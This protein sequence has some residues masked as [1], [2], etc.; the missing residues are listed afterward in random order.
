VNSL[1]KE[2]SENGVLARAARAYPQRGHSRPTHASKPSMIM[3]G[4]ITP[5][6]PL[7]PLKAY[8]QIGKKPIEL[9]I[10]QHCSVQ[11]VIECIIQVI[12]C[13][14]CTLVYYHDANDC[15]NVMCIGVES[16]KS[17]TSNEREL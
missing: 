3:S 17:N 15:V 9:K 12:Y 7:V 6:G 16:I 11:H 8:V 5:S 1:S 10:H 2:L 4:H 13:Y 14:E